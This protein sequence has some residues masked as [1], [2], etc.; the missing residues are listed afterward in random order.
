MSRTRE[1]MQK[2]RA[3]GLGQYPSQ[4]MRDAQHLMNSHFADVMVL[5]RYKT[6][7]IGD[8]L[9]QGYEGSCVGFGFTDWENSKPTGF[10]VQQGYDYAYAYYKRAQE[11]DEW[12]GTDYEGTSARA[13]ARVAL[14]RGLLSEYVWASSRADIDAW[15]LGKGT[16]VCA[17]YWFRSMDY[18]DGDGFLNV[19]P[20]S[21]IRGGHCY[22][23]FGIGTEGNYKFQ[24]S[25]GYDYANDG[26]FRLRPADLERLIAAGGFSAVAAIQTGVA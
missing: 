18:P 7:E 6:H 24:N 11:L 22:L 12:W 21:G 23:L 9:D 25:W 10:A 16:V 1:Q 8:T 2:D 14:E 13:G 19:A 3:K 20:D 4:D 5:P 15:I 17:S 26:T